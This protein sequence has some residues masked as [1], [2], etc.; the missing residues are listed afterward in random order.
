MGFHNSLGG[1]HGSESITPPRLLEEVYGKAFQAAIAE[2]DLRGV[3][4]C[5]CT[6][7]GEAASSSKRMLTEILRQEMGFDG[8][9]VADYSAIENQHQVQGLYE[10]KEETGLRS[11]EA[12]MDMEWPKRSCYNENL[13][14]WFADKKVDMEILD[15]T[16]ERILT[17]K[18][19]MGLFE[20]PF[21]LEGETLQQEFISREEDARLSLKAAEESMVLLKITE[22]C[23]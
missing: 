7:D 15:R 1:I 20:H 18:F 8:L 13:M 6:F 19:R 14:A 16:V 11:M 21:A 3:M 17:A 23:L 22:C 9:A 5:Y 12:G 10:S 2:A 4:P